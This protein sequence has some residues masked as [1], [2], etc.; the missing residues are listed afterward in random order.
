MPKTGGVTR[1]LY[2]G[3]Y[4]RS[5][6]LIASYHGR[7]G[8]ERLRLAYFSALRLAGTD[9]SCFCLPNSKKEATR[10]SPVILDGARPNAPLSAVLFS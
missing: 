10:R 2:T 8:C 9:K 4:D 7:G 3:C 5:R 1:A 6:H